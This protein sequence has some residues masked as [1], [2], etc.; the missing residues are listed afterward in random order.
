MSTRALRPDA[1]HCSVITPSRP[2]GPEE[3]RRPKGQSH[4]DW[5]MGLVALAAKL[6]P[7]TDCGFYYR[8]EREQYNEWLNRCRSESHPFPEF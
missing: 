5:V 4:I 7:S 1:A 6:R 8:G 3:I 2:A